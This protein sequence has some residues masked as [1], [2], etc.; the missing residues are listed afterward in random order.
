MKRLLSLLA[1]AALPTLALEPST[2]TFSVTVSGAISPSDARAIRY[3]VD[4]ENIRRSTQ[5]GTNIVYLPTNSAAQ[6]RASAVQVYS[7]LIAGAHIDAIN[8]AGEGTA[9]AKLT[10]DQR[11]DINAA[12]ADQLQGGLDPQ[13][14]VDAL[15]A[16]K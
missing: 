7:N 12:I 6:Y 15:K 2:I 5:G 16:A 9:T 8:K 10:D 14:L 3:L 13:K 11:R 4:A 1:I